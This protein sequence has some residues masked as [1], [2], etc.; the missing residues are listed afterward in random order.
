M[1]GKYNTATST[2][3]FQDLVVWVSMIFAWNTATQTAMA[4]SK[5]TTETLKQGMKYVQSYK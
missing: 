3:K 5:L 4:C 2:N 1:L